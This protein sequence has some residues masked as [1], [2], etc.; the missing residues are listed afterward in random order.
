MEFIDKRIGVI[1][2]ELKRISV[3]QKISIHNWKYKKGNYVYP[4]DADKAKEEWL[5]FDSK[6]MHWYG[7]DEHYWFRSE[8]SVPECLHNKPMWLLQIRQLQ[9]IFIKLI[10]S[11]IQELCILNLI[12]L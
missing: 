3:T 1:C 7:P 6:T 5:E 12:Y 4:E 8:F 11:H 2:D 10:Y 9:M